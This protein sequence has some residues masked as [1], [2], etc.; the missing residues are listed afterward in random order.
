MKAIAPDDSLKWKEEGIVRGAV[1]YTHLYQVLLCSCS[2]QKKRYLQSMQ[3]TVCSHASFTG[4]VGSFA[5]LLLVSACFSLVHMALL[6]IDG[7]FHKT[8][9]CIQQTGRKQNT[10]CTDYDIDGTQ[11]I[12]HLPY[13]YILTAVR[14]M[15]RQQAGGIVKMM[16]IPLIVDCI[17]IQ[18]QIDL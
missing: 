17:A 4:T 7:R 10:S 13:T 12:H 9:C 18:L 1:S 2:K 16:Q 3:N 11:H 5:S 6:G 14:L 15:C 8:I